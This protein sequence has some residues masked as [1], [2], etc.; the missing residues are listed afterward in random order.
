[1]VSIAMKRPTMNGAPMR[2][3]NGSPLDYEVEVQN[4]S[5]APF[6]GSLKVLTGNDTARATQ[7]ITVM[8]GQRKYLIS[9]PLGFASCN[10]QDVIIALTKGD[11]RIDTM[12]ARVDG[13][14]KMFGKPTIPMA[15]VPPDR[16]AEMQANSLSFYDVKLAREPA[17]N[18]LI[19]EAT[20][21]NRSSIAT[22]A[23]LDVRAPEGAPTASKAEVFDIG[24][25]ETKKVT[26]F[27][28]RA[29]DGKPGVYTVEMKDVTGRV[30][31][32]QN[33]A[34]I[35]MGRACNPEIQN[36][37]RLAPRP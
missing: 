28:M 19:F 36:V 23:S 29:F 33:G 15:N 2:Y 25:G 9:D 6:S 8:P 20:A 22:R 37:R 18:S 32:F 13:Q 14:C 17:C 10:T 35:E 34:G 24:P 21:I 16:K 7:P 12:L 30:N 5:T 26:N 1:M 31:V 27:G 4:T 11:A 3:S